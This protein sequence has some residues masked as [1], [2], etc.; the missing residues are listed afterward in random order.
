[1]NYW[2]LQKRYSKWKKSVTKD[3]ILYDPI[4]MQFLERQTRE[5][6]QCL[7]GVGEGAERDAPGA[8]GSQRK[9]LTFLLKS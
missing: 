2:Y 3:Y 9:S 5:T 6:E 4:Y 8:E 1:M 7:L